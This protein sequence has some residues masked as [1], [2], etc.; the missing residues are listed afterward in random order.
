MG[1]MLAKLK[2]KKQE[3]VSLFLKSAPNDPLIY[4]CPDSANCVHQIK[5]VLKQ[6]GVKGKHTNAATQLA[7]NQAL[8][9]FK[10]IQIREVALKYDPCID[11]V[12][13][14]IDLYGKAAERFEFAGDI[15]HE[16]V[17]IHMQ[18]FLALLLTVSILHGS[19]KKPVDDEY[20]SITT[21]E[22]FFLS[23]KKEDQNKMVGDEKSDSVIRSPPRKY[24][25]LQIHRDSI[26]DS[27]MLVFRHA[28]SPDH[29]RDCW[30]CLS[31]PCM[32][33]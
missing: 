1:K 32:C 24:N 3:S 33:D 5:E 8:H 27:R 4:M 12:N 29:V 26:F 10:T 21:E 2:F 20:I 23:A 11:R 25:E 14:I 28:Q 22:G 9:Y 19:C 6:Y 30:T 18:K 15:R 7:I 31:S 16:K 13:D 17:K